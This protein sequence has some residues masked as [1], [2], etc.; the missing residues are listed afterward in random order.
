MPRDAEIQDLLL[1][2]G[3]F[4]H[5]WSG[6]CRIDSQVGSLHRVSWNL[7]IPGGGYNRWTE[8]DGPVACRQSTSQIENKS[9][10]KDEDSTKPVEVRGMRQGQHVWV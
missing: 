10:L 3:W 9:G 6:P 7:G 5:Q 8:E 1:G 4:A 2:G